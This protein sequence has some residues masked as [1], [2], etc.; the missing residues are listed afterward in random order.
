VGSDDARDWIVRADVEDF[1][2]SEVGGAGC[3][4]VL[5]GREEVEAAEE[6]EEEVEEEVEE[7]AVVVLVGVG[8]FLKAGGAEAG[9]SAA[10]AG[11]T[12]AFLVDEAAEGAF[13]AAAVLTGGRLELAMRL[14]A[15]IGCG[16]GLASV[17]VISATDDSGGDVICELSAGRTGTCWMSCSTSSSPDRVER[18]EE[19]SARGGS[20]SHSSSMSGR[21]SRV[22][23]RDSPSGAVCPATES[24]GR[25]GGGTKPDERR[26]A[27]EE[28]D[29][30]RGTTVS[31]SN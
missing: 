13:G 12:T 19:G 23:D 15:L 2:V 7:D 25:M 18:L 3:G 20:S 6:E 21:L 26:T 29:C 24:G 14:T 8:G 1:R 9:G 17:D 11:G 28:R 22:S 31:S 4:A 27:R 5:E 16:S 30:G 10:G